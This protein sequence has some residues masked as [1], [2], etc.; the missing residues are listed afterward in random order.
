MNN[1]DNLTSN[2]LIADEIR[3]ILDEKRTSVSILSTGIFILLAQITIQGILIATSQFYKIIDVLHI[4]I[5]FYIINIA[6]AF[7]S[8]YLI[9]HSLLRI[10]HYNHLIIK[11]KKRHSIFTDFT[12]S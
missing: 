10:R 1:N 12:D 3:L 11:L 4:V 7:L 5:P 6:L 2:R 8:F 9:I